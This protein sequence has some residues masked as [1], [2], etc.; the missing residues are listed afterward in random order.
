MEVELMEKGMVYKAF[1]KEVGNYSH[2]VNIATFDYGWQI[3]HNETALR[4][5]KSK[6]GRPRKAGSV[7]SNTFYYPDLKSCI[8]GVLG[9]A[10]KLHAEID[11]LEDIHG[12]IHRATNEILE[13]I[14][15]MEERKEAGNAVG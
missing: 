6:R 10:V 12:I 8:S 2:L 13:A 1:Q 3:I 11:G 4:E 14:R 7:R 9:L 5:I 15:S